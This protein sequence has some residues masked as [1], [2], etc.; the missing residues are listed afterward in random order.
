MLKTQNSLTKM[1]GLLLPGT[2]K[3]SNSSQAKLLNN[4]H[5]RLA[6]MAVARA[7]VIAYP[8][9]AVFGLG[10]SPWHEGAVSR[11]LQ[12]KRRPRSKG[13][14]VVAANISQLDSL[15]NFS[16]IESIAPI[17]DSWPGHV[18]WILPAHK[19]TPRWLTGANTDIA[20]R[21][22]A[23]P[24]LSKLCELSGPLVS[25]SANISKS[26][27]ALT[28]MDVRNYFRDSLDYILPGALGAER[29]TSEIRHG[30][31]GKIIR[32]GRR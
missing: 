24:T 2:G 9:E 30:K 6:V 10:C 31:S 25:T 5:I 23:H 13:L 20:V 15:V 32:Q 18:T 14:I 7:G 1:P 17:L 29:N 27:A 22:T 26:S 16:K 21:V 3:R 8:T 12:L 28:V 4:W 11:L 19:D